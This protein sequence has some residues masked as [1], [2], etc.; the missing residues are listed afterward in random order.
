IYGGLNWNPELRSPLT[1]PGINAV[2]GEYIL[3]VNGKEVTAAQNLFSFFENTSGKIVELTLGSNPNLT[4]SR[5]VKVVPVAG[6]ASLRNRDWVEGN[7]KKVT[8]ATNGQVAYVYVPNTANQGHEYFKRYF[9]PQANRKAIIIDERFNGGGQIANY[10]IDLL[11][12]P[13]HAHWNTRYGKDFKTPSASIQG[14]KVMLIDETA[15]SGGDMLPWMFRKFK[16]GTLVGKRTWGGLVGILGFPEFIDGAS[17]TAPN[18]A[19]WTQ[20]GFIVENVGVPPDV[21][22][23]QIPSEVIKGNDPQLQKAIEIAL[24]ELKKNPPVEYKRPAYPVRVKKN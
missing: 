5:I 23:E 13:Y 6:E 8:A 3:A 1:E 20:D 17:V 11:Q 10:Y 16:V 18:L 15:G 2:V 22:V 24:E 19:I 9:Y 7:L 12:Q 4:G 21:E 14:P